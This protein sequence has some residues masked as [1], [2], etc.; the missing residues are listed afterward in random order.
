MFVL[1]CTKISTDSLPRSNEL[2]LFPHITSSN[3]PQTRRG[4]AFSLLGCSSAL[5]STSWTAYGRSEAKLGDCLACWAALSG[6]LSS[7]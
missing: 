3:T 2:F 6:I 7:A 4:D 5:S 1:H